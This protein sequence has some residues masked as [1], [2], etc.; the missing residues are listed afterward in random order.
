MLTKTKNKLNRKDQI[1]EKAT[2]LFQKQGYAATSMRDLAGFIGIEAA[3]LY[4]HIKSKEE[5]LQTICFQMAED[6]FSSLNSIETVG[7]QA[8]QKLR[9]AVASHVEVL[10]KDPA[11]SAVFVSEWRHLSEPY[12]SDFLNMRNQY[13]NKFIQIIIDGNKAGIFKIVDAKFTV[14]A[15]L[16]SVNWMPAWYKPN[17]KLSPREIAENVTDVFIN[18]LK[19]R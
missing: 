5:I 6:F 13:E 3:S 19:V 17:G 11:A 12:L 15:L 9:A 4:S 10:T 16:S 1:I 7:S 8:D 2:Q 14:L 18:G